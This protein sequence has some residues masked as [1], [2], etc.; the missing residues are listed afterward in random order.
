M[1]TKEFEYQLAELRPA[2]YQFTKKFTRSSEDSSD[3]VQETLAKA[4]KKRASFRE[5]K[6]LIG[7]L[8]II[9]RNTFVNQYRKNR[10]VKN[11]VTNDQPYKWRDDHG[12]TKADESTHLEELWKA[13][14]AI[15]PDLVKP[16]KMHLSG[17]KYEEIATELNIP[18]GTVK[19]R[20]FLARQEIRNQL[21][22]YC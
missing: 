10:Q 20:L 19:S 13:I 6:N 1:K 16:F 22:G 17:Y 15:N 5:N 7:W 9:M 12:V 11:R 14:N 8:Y 21:P 3:L 18:L 4:W 2:L